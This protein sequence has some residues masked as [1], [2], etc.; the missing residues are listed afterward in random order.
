[1]FLGLFRLYL[2]LKCCSK[3]LG[4]FRLIS[5]LNIF[6]EI[7]EKILVDKIMEFL[8]NNNI[9]FSNQYGFR[10]NNSTELSVTTMMSFLKILIVNCIHVQYFSILRKLLIQLIIMFC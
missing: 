9:L 1:M 3:E 7:F 5:L 10:A 4:D 2:Y 6:A 8:D